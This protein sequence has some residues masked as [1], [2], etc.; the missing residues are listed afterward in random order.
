LSVFNYFFINYLT[1]ALPCA[2]ICSPRMM[3]PNGHTSTHMEDY[4]TPLTSVCQ[5]VFLFIPGKF[6]GFLSFLALRQFSPSPLPKGSGIFC[7]EMRFQPQGAASP[8]RRFQELWLFAKIAHRGR[9][10]RRTVREAGPYDAFRT[11]PGNFPRK[12]SR[13]MNPAAEIVCGC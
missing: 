6:S 9:F 2:T 4:F 8:M 11:T 5:W 12:N 3:T 7:A 1:A 10:F 13:R